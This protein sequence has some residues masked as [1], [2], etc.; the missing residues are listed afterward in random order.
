MRT[1]RNG[2]FLVAAALVLILAG[3]AFWWFSRPEKIATSAPA[4]TPAVNSC[5]DVDEATA[6]A[7]FPWKGSAVDCTASH[8]VEVYY[9]GQADADLIR[10]DHKAKGDDKTIAD[11]LMYAQVRI[12]CG[13]FASVQLGGNWHSGRVAVVANWVDPARD[14]FFGCAL[15]QVADPAG[16]H[17][18]ARTASLK[19]AL[20]GSGADS[21]AAGCVDA[22]GTYV[23]CDQV[24]L[25]E[26]VGW[27][28]ITPANAPFD[29]K[30][31]QA[32]VTKGCGDLV[33]KYL[34][35]PP[36]PVRSDV[37]TAYVGP[38]TATDWLGS[39]QTYACYARA[40]TNVR[41]SIRNLGTRPLPA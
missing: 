27:Y 31:L 33:G 6:R 12:A 25:S 37:T 39:D 20:S 23:A 40:A 30:G 2:K 34:G 10:Q 21:L 16:K 38:T 41:A 18:V 19:G 11:N 26:Y 17:F 29:A 7:A 13:D 8:T 22:N 5:W 1:L 28:T 32:A 3:V 14:G 4:G 35:Q 24:H 15:A 9:I 36:G